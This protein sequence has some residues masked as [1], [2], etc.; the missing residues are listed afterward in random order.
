MAGDIKMNEF[1]SETDCEYIYVELANGNQGKLNKVELIKL[2]S[3]YYP[4][5]EHLKYGLG[6]VNHVHNNTEEISA[7]SWVYAVGFSDGEVV[8]VSFEMDAGTA[9]SIYR[10]DGYTM[11]FY[12]IASDT[13]RIAKTVTN[14]GGK[15]MLIFS[16]NGSI[17]KLMVERGY[18]ASDWK[19]G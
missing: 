18:F 2:I 12:F 8:T 7:N 17:R 6:G 16:E 4:Q 11:A 10:D 15:D 13:N 5:I 1:A 9:I 14:L 3:R 19:Q